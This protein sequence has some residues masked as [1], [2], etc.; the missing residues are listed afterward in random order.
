MFLV[1]LNEPAFSSLLPWVIP[2]ASRFGDHLLRR[3]FTALIRMRNRSRHNN[4]MSRSIYYYYDKREWMVVSINDEYRIYYYINYLFYLFF[5]NWGRH[6]LLL[7]TSTESAVLQKYQFW[8]FVM[9]DE[10]ITWE[11]C[12][13]D[14]SNNNNN[15]I[16][17]NGNG[18]SSA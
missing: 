7:S 15:I 6:V 8:M 3:Y 10:Y 11:V 12:D 17:I 13:R 18:L 16:L 2:H 5:N 14:I 4:I 1:R 9:N